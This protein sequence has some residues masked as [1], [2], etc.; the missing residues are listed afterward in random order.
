MTEKKLKLETIFQVLAVILLIYTAILIN[1]KAVDLPTADL[2]RHITNGKIIFHSLLEQNWK[3]LELVLHT[4]LYSYTQPEHNFVNH[5][6]LAGLIYYLLESSAGLSFLSFFNVLLVLVSNLLFFRSAQI[7][8]NTNIALFITSISLPIACL[9]SEVRPESFSYLFLGIV[10]Y[11]LVLHDKGKL[12]YKVLLPVI[13]VVQLI[14]INCHIFFFLGFFLCFCFGLKYL[15][16]KDQEKIKQ[17]LILGASITLVSLLNPHG[18]VGLLYPLKIFDGYG[19]MTVEN[20]SV[21]F[22][23]KREPRSI[24]YYYYEF[25]AL[26]SLILALINGKKGNFPLTILGFFFILLGFKV[27]R[28]M[29]LGA[30]FVVPMNAYNL[31]CIFASL[32]KHSRK[33]LIA[34]MAI[35]GFFAWFYRNQIGKRIDSFKF[36]PACNMAA[37]VIKDFNINGPIFNN[38]DIGG[39]MIYHLYPARRVFV[40]NRPEAY[41]EDF[42]NDIY[43]KVLKE[44]ASWKAL[45]KKINFNAIVF[46]RHDLTEHG[47]PFLIRRI[48][49]PLWIPVFVDNENI[50]LVKDQEKNKKIIEEMAL[51]ESIF[52]AVKT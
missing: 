20:Q 18:L 50:I 8:T 26:Y 14:W 6:W 16:Q 48:A 35:L 28:A 33:L 30:L 42:L 22:L 41:D 47:Q 25:I 44:E 23:Q 10:L 15:I 21:F 45:D 43:L 9:R 1:A 46:Y 5:H 32:E 12:S 37:R 51:P 36:N 13:V 49:D 7:L 17:F 19:Y 3:T 27:S 34:A 31:N 29:T 38:F 39:Y 24:G 40:D 4:N 11:L 2:G 52:K